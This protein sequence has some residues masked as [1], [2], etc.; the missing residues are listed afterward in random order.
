LRRRNQHT[1]IDGHCSGFYRFR[2]GER[3]LPQHG[4]NG[5]RSD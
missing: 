1:K 3:G 2:Q 5:Y 4:E